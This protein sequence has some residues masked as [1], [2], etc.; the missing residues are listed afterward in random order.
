MLMKEINEDL[1]KWREMT[2]NWKTQ[3]SNDVSSPQIDI[4]V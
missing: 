1:H 3:H 2:M 4:Q